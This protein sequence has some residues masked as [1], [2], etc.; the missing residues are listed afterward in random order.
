MKRLL[1]DHLRDAWV[2][3]F[4][5]GVI[6]LNFPF[7]HIVNKQSTVFGIPALVLYF[8]VGWPVSIVVIYFFARSLGARD[9]SGDKDAT[10]KPRKGHG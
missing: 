8:L 7:I 1:T 4:I 10:E 6:M 2:L 3:C 5:L 9:D